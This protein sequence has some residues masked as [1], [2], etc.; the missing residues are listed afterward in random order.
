LEQQQRYKK[1]K[2]DAFFNDGKKSL[3]LFVW[4]SPG[5]GIGS[6]IDSTSISYEHNHCN[7]WRGSHHI[8]SNYPA[9]AVVFSSV[10]SVG[11]SAELWPYG[12]RMEM[13]VSEQ[14]V[15]SE[16]LAGFGK[17]VLFYHALGMQ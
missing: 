6:R 8:Y 16:K 4:C 2:E 10:V 1:E 17:V 15:L 3:L 5:S 11:Y 9:I 14:Y 13:H 7:T 12:T